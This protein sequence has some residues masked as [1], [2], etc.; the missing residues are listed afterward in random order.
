MSANFLNVDLEIESPESL[1]HLCCELIEGGAF[2]L[3]NGESK[4]GY[5]AAFE[6]EHGG[7]EDDPNSIIAR[8]CN[9]LDRMDERAKTT[10]NRAH[11]RSFDIGYETDAA[12]GS[13]HSELKSETVLRIAAHQA[14]V[15]ITL[16]PRPARERS[17]GGANPRE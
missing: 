8:F 7:S 11:R 3:Y 15:R 14:D 2:K 17:N 9:L 5:L 10:W 13:F 4:S 12:R 16:Y 1:D 6:V